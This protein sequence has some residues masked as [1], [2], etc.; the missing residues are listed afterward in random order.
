MVIYARNEKVFITIPC[1]PCTLLTGKQKNL[2]S[3][4]AYNKWD[5]HRGEPSSLKH[6]AV[7]SFHNILNTCLL[8]PVEYGTLFVVIKQLQKMKGYSMCSHSLSALFIFV[9]NL[10]IVLEFENTHKLCISYGETKSFLFAH[11]W[12]VPSFQSIERYHIAT[13][14]YLHDAVGCHDPVLLLQHGLYRLQTAGPVC[15]C[16]MDHQKDLFCRQASLMSHLS[17]SSVI[18]HHNGLQLI[19]SMHR[20]L[21]LFF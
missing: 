20:S 17:L 19:N 1:W 18:F 6:S 5:K 9:L 7:L 3:F 16:N 21:F 14:T 2:R 4:L 8:P 13:S 11:G 12:E 10:K 15:W